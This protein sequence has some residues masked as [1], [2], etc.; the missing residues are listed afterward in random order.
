[1]AYLGKYVLQVS[2]VFFAFKESI[3]LSSVFE[4]YGYKFKMK[5]VFSYKKVY[6]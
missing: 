1:M 4:C 6:N 3:Q 2:H 5:D